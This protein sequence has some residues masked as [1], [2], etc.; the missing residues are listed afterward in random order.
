MV[1]RHPHTFIL[2]SF[3][4][5]LNKDANGNLLPPAIVLEI[6][7]EGRAQV[8]DTNLIIGENGDQFPVKHTIT[9]PLQD[10]D[11][12]GGNII[13]AGKSYPIIRWRNYQNRSKAWL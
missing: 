3:S 4:D 9:F 2:Q 13:W 1:E 8:S 11:F 6:E 7:C 10:S 5:V 12:S